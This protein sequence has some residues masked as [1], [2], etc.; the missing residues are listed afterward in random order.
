MEEDR[1][2]AGRARDVCEDEVEVLGV[3]HHEHD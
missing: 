3:S 1:V 2:K